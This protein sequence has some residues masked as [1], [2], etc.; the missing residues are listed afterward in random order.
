MVSISPSQASIPINSDTLF[1]LR[2]HSDTQLASLSLSGALSG[3]NCEI[4]EVKTDSLNEKEVKI[5]KNISG[6]SFDM[7]LSFTTNSVQ[8]LAAA[9]IQLKIKFMSKGKY[10]LNIGDINAYDNKRN[11]V[12]IAGASC[13]IDVY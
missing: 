6:N 5:L 3:G 13:P 12:E 2:I 7:G 8:T 11:K 4:V 1:S 10:I 9:F